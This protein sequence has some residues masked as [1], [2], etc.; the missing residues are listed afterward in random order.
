M[1]RKDKTPLPSPPPPQTER[2][3]DVLDI[4]PDDYVAEIRG[5]WRDARDEGTVDETRAH[6]GLQHAGITGIQEV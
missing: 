5:D 6:R 4:S 2:W 1:T 3:D